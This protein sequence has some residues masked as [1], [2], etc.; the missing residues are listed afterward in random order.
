M[1]RMKRIIA[2][3]VTIAVSVMVLFGC[4]AGSAA[5]A[6]SG[7]PAITVHVTIDGSEAEGDGYHVGG[8]TDV[9]LSDGASAYDALEAACE[10]LG[11]EIKGSPS[12]VKWIGELGEKA[13]TSSSG[14]G[15]DINGDFPTVAADQCKLSDG[16]TLTWK[17]WR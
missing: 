14:W 17:F 6:V 5:P 4:A 2:I 8:R 15:F 1:N 9:V 7:G 16:D 13:I 10:T 12:Y 3:I 11:Y